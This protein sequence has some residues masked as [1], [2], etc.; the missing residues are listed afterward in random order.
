[1]KMLLIFYLF[2][3]L[4]ANGKTIFEINDEIMGLLAKPELS[5]LSTQ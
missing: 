1:M 3:L 4:L 5:I 2:N